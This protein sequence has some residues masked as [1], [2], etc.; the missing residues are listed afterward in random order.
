MVIGTEMCVRDSA[1]RIGLSKSGRVPLF[2]GLMWW[3]R[4][5]PAG[6]LFTVPCIVVESFGVGAK[7]VVF[8]DEKVTLTNSIDNVQLFTD[9]IPAGAWASTQLD[10]PRSINAE[11]T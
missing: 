9:F 5:E 7:L 2:L 11:F 10:Q 3:A 6:L 8:Y 1:S 4:P